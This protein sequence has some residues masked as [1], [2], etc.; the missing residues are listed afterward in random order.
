MLGISRSYP[1]S[2]KC[3]LYDCIFAILEVISLLVV[4]L[5]FGYLCTNWTSSRLASYLFV[6]SCDTIWVDI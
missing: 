1:R 2:F 4:I 6:K 5:S 3:H